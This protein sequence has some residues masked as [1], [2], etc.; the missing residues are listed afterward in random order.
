[1]IAYLNGRLVEKSPTFV[2]IDVAGIGYHVFISL[3]TFS[4][5]PQ[6]ESCKLY[7]E[8][9]VREDAQLLYGFINPAEKE[10]FQLLT[11]VSGVGPSTAMMVLS[12]GDSM[13]IQEAIITGDVAWFKGVKGIGPKSAQRI[14]IDLKDKVAKVNLDSDNL[15]FKDNTLKDEALSALVMLGFN[16]NKA[17]KVVSNIL[18]SNQNLS[19]EDVIKNALKGL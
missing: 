17:E 7:T 10:L 14:I 2:V 19:V 8:L 18:R 15:T 6:E 3:N 13:E 4:K 1:M 5:L 16:K 9:V 12:A 11:S